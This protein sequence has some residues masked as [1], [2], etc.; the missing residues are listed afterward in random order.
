VPLL[1]NYL[2]ENLAQDEF[3]AEVSGGIVLYLNKIK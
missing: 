3:N 1:S 2:D